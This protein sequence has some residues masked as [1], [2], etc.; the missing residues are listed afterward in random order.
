MWFS[1]SILSL[2]PGS[3][4]LVFF[5]PGG[6]NLKLISTKNC[7]LAA[8]PRTLS[9]SLSTSWCSWIVS[10]CIRIL[11]W[12]RFHLPCNNGENPKGKKEIS[13]SW[14]SSSWTAIFFHN[15]VAVQFPFTDTRIA[16]QLTGNIIRDSLV[17]HKPSP[18][19][20][21][22]VFG[23]ESVEKEEIENENRN[24]KCDEGLMVSG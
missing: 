8:S 23:W 15:V 22:L 4:Y 19:L 1:V 11:S 10:W 13:S 7:H 18:T 12:K 16:Q 9:L 20:A 24:R 2:P 14:I 5:V 6:Y 3:L 17:I 21:S